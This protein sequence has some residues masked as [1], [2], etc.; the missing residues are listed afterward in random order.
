MKRILQSNSR[1]NLLLVFLLFSVQTF[2]QETLIKNGDTWSYF[3][4]G[5]LNDNW[6][7]GTDFS[8]WK[9]GVT[10]IGYGDRI[11]TT[12]I[13]F[14]KSKEDKDLVKYFIKR[15]NIKNLSKF[16]GIEFK[17]QRDDGAVVYV[18]GKEL[19]RDN[20]P[21]GNITSETKSLHV[22]NTEEEK[23]FYKKVFDKS[24]FKEGLNT[25]AVGVHQYNPYSSDCIFSMEVVGHNDPNVLIE[26]VK[27]QIRN[28]NSLEAKIDEL[29][30]SF[31][32]KNTTTQLEIYKNTNQNLKFFLGFISLLLLSIIT[33]FLFFLYKNKK[34]EEQTKNEIQQINNVTLEKEKEMISYSNQ[35]LYQK[36]HLK[37]IKAD[38][39]FANTDN[40]KAIQNIIKQID[41]IIDNKD[42]WKELKLHFN[43]V[44]DG[45]YDSL[46]SKC[47]SLT[48][49]EL[50]HCMFIKLHMQT[51]E[52]ARILN[53]DPRSVQTARYRIKK[54]LNLDEDQ[55]LRSFLITV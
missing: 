10:P 7:E 9:L 31:L 36:Q 2:S 42:E 34:N 32:L 53:I 5:Y 54:K 28:K 37:E 30:S 45:F 29:N 52:I 11:V 17:L 49:T 14:G 39:K 51:K 43:A 41:F 26:V 50:R 16:T 22:I 6:Y 25:I 8:N 1:K 48:E 24:I 40:N 23:I 47:S 35:L 18:N 46:I 38:L 33:A 15:I 4:Q 21:E 44:Y 13:H 19:Y 55:D 12:N 20:M 27:N 3:D